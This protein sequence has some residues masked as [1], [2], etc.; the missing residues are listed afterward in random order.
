[1]P[2]VNNDAMKPVVQLFLGMALGLFASLPSNANPGQVDKLIKADNA[3]HERG[4][5]QTAGGINDMAFLRRVTV[6]LIGRIPT[7]KEIKQYLAWPATERRA[8]L[9]ETLLTEARY[10]DR[11]T[12][13]FADILRIRS[14]ATGGNSLLAYMHKAV[15]ENRPWD[16]LAREMISANGT[17]G[18][19]P[20]VG[21]ILGEDA[22]PMSLAAATSQM[23]LGV[24]MQCAQCHN[25]PFDVWKQ[26]QFYELATYFGKTRRV[27][28]QFSRRVYTT[29][30]K[31]T[32]V[33][34]PP[35]R[36]KPPERFPVAPKF[37]IDFDEYT[38]KP[39]F[40]KR[41][42]AK[43]EAIRIAQTKGAEGKQLDDL[44]DDVDTTKAFTK[45]GFNRDVAEEAKAQTRALDV[46]GDLY[47]QSVDRTTLSKL[48][49][50]PYNRYFSR[51]MVNRLWAELVG[52]GFYEPVDNFQDIVSHKQTLNYLCEEFV[53]QGYDV[54]WLISTIVQTQAYARGHLGDS[55]TVEEIRHAE[56]A[57]TATRQRRM[58]SEV[59]Y[60]SVVIAGHLTDYKW[61]AGVNIRT[62][63]ERV[64]IPIGPVEGG[65][66]QPGT[67]SPLPPSGQPNMQPS[68]MAMKA[69]GGYD[70]ENQISLNFDELLKSE[71]KK[72]LESMKQMSD[73]ELERQRRM[74]EMAMQR[75]ANNPRMR[76]KSELVERKV[77]DNPR[78][79]STMRMATPAPPAHFL[80]VFGQPARDGLGQFRDETPSMRQQLMMLNGKATH[81]ASR[82]GPFEPM[83][84]LLGVDKQNVDGAI[85]LAYLEILTRQP[86]A[87]E[88]AF[89]K[90]VVG[91][92]KPA[93]DGMADLRW[94]LFN[95]NEFRYLP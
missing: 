61:P 50:H 65:E 10:A 69:G 16:E 25:H 5:T 93:M 58:I 92:G 84:K 45:A 64:R 57:F 56:E 9:V 83:Y 46:V 24:R 34:W 52:R 38:E 35:E 74:Q 2:C 41:L 75:Q 73:A 40:V 95:S 51:N 87:E 90:Q 53:A 4:I 70:L 49:T 91:T 27:E 11:W 89:A 13:F 22:D 30:A 15:R 33:L 72:D 86:D 18:K 54:K 62:Y 85:R 14:N 67:A 78:F 71:L 59:L 42:E 7:H 12:V 55:H 29:E 36:R 43:R 26:K 37:P 20:A 32:T 17:T 80:R 88:L 19:V 44:L 6:D 8:K 47:K 94:A 81:E 1:M 21:F 31:D 77:D 66:S 68:M 48:I 60:D 23:F 3:K 28:N 79:G 76:Y 39:S 63:T 82:V